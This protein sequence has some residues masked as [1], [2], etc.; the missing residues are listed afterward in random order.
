MQGMRE[1]VASYKRWQ[2]LGRQVL[3]GARAKEVIVPLLVNVQP[4]EE[5]IEAEKRERVAKLIG[6][7]VVRGVFAY[8]DTGGEEVPP[9]PVLRWDLGK[10]LDTLK[11]TRVL[12]R[13][14]NG[15][16]HGYS[17][18]REI[19]I[20]PMAPHP[21][22][23]MLHE[24]GHIVLGHTVATRRGEYGQHR[25]KMEFG[26]EATAYLAGHELD[27]IDEETASHSQA[28]IRH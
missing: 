26:A 23:T 11:I 28:Y 1:P 2:G 12:F 16:V 21:E 13:N 24:M 25:G 5:E 7:K 3:K 15:N 14:L 19:A 9:K 4:P 27:I 22:R 6:F 8:S 17:V 18:G 10:A 20:N